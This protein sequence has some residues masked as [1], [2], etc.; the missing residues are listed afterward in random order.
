[1]QH[2]DLESAEQ[3][4]KRLCKNIAKASIDIGQNTTIYITVSSG[5]TMLDPDTPVELSID[6]ADKALYMAK[7]AGGNCVRVW[8]ASL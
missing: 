4:A 7:S 8:D 1:M 5:L 6:H 3:I 2:T